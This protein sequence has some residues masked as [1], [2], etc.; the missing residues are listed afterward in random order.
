MALFYLLSRPYNRAW[1]IRFHA[2]HSIILF[3]AWILIWSL[4]ELAEGLSTWLLASVIDD[5]Q[6]GMACVGILAWGALMHAA[7][8]GKRLVIIQPIH[9][10]AS[11]LASRVFKDRKPWSNESGIL[12][13]ARAAIRAMRFREEGRTFIRARH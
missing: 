13:S 6:L 4:L 8:K 2:V 5:I 3:S 11:R 10:F 1:A 12:S 9:V 7:C